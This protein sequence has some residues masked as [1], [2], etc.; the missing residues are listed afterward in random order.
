MSPRA[1]LKA[2][3]S[4]ARAALTAP[5]S[6]RPSPLTFVVGNES[7][8]LDSLCS[9]LLLAYFHT[10][11]PPA[12][13]A[14]KAEDRTSTTATGIPSTGTGSLHIPLCHLRRADLALRPEFAALLQDAGVNSGDVFTFEDIFSSSSPSLQQG[15]SDDK[16]VRIN[17]E[18]SH[19]PT[20]LINPD[21]TR[22]LLVDHNV[23]TGV[24][25]RVFGHR[26]VGCVDHHADE[27][28][29]SPDAEIRIIEKS[30]SCA[31]LVLDRCREAWDAAATTAEAK[32]KGG[33][34]RGGELKEIDAQLA[35]LALGPILIDTGNLLDGTK[36]TAYD[37]RAV[38]LAEGK[39]KAVDTGYERD[40]FFDRIA[41]LKDDLDGMGFRDVLRKDY[42]E[43]SA[44][45]GDA[46]SG[47][48]RLH[49]GTCSVS[50]SFEYLVDGKAEGDAGVFLTELAKWTAEKDNNCG[51]D[52]QGA[53]GGKMDLVAVFTG[54]KDT[55]GQFCRELLVWALT[56]PGIKAAE[57]FERE[58]AESLGLGPWRG[59]ELD[60]VKVKAG[61]GDWRKGWKQNSV[62]ASRKQIAPMLRDAMQKVSG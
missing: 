16:N 56:A 8:D 19:L 57:I 42:K 30:G 62:A 44:G 14:T 22:W 54:F 34:E 35:R 11:T 46:A 26:V 10:Y 49:L 45:N 6:K 23:M 18:S 7:A 9:A 48:S 20:A 28:V 52:G 55:E 41:A 53:N 24:L 58:N 12:A 15:G 61:E 27:H 2:F 37:T 3:L 4:V 59:G 43:W 17:T 38:E 51:S 50:R 60:L 33:K 1:S 47:K 39:I 36:T 32:E 21:D 29:I 25:G 40:G 13:A 31:S 5:P